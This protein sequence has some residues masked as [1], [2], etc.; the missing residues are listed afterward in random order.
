MKDLE[1]YVKSKEGEEEKIIIITALPCM[2]EF[3]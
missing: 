3:R 2:E 1:S